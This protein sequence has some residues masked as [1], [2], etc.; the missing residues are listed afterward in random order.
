MRLTTD[1]LLVLGLILGLWAPLP[2]IAGDASGLDPQAIDQCLADGGGDCTDAG[3]EACRGYAKEKYSGDD[4]DFIEK[5]C[6]DASHQAWEAKL[7]EAYEALLAQEAEAGITP[8][9]TLRQAEHS[10]I[11]FRDDLCHYEE[12]AASARDLSGGVALLEC[13]RDE[14]A[15]HWALL[16]AR[17]ETSDE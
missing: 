16:N 5:N 9:E 6:L 15:R 12:T 17:L 1:K 10:W 7:G 13:Q 14:A 4:P 8:E 3:M 2:S 11:T